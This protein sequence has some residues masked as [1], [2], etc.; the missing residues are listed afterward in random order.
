MK[1]L[2]LIDVQVD[3]FPGGAL[4]VK[5]GD[6][7]LPAISELVEMEWDLIIASKDWHPAKHHSFAS[8]HG[9]KVGESVEDQILWPDHCVQG[10]EGAEFYPGWNTDLVN[11]VVYK[12]TSKEV[13]S[14]SAFFD[15]DKKRDTGLHAYLQEQGV[16][17][18]Y[19]AGLATDYCVKATVLDALNL[20]Y[21]VFVIQDG[22]EAV[23]LE[24][25]DG[26]KALKEMQEA[27]A[28]LITL[29]T[30]QDVA[31]S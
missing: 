2:L 7:I 16:T 1:A 8:T 3:F 23:N 22:I 28:R 18:L 26:Q 29:E 9:K 30:L 10:T 4:A 25:E 31:A 27:G 15:N 24:P 13:D 17:E 20:G 5:R 14:Y 21:Q 12:G 19:C 11:Y 6:R